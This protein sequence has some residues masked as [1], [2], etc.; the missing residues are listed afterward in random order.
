MKCSPGNGI[1]FTAILQVGCWVGCASKC[2]CFTAQ[3]V[4]LMLPR[5]A[6]RASSG[7]CSNISSV[8]LIVFVPKNAAGTGKAAKDSTS[9]QYYNMLGSS[10]LAA[11]EARKGATEP[12][13]KGEPVDRKLF[14]QCFHLLK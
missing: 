7:L 3:S 1:R 14:K 6:P 13:L 10:G 11:K 5:L 9:E 4:T 12:A 8:P 2:T